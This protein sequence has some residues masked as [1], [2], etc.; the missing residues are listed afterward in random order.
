MTRPSS[1]R[2]RFGF[3]LANAAIWFLMTVVLVLVP[4]LLEEWVGLEVAR[5]IG[6]AAAGGLWMVTIE[7]QWQA[8]FGVFTRFALQLLLWISAA[9]VAIW[10]SE[11]TRP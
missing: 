6:W 3:V 8:R 9:L 2:G 5:V 1:A 11:I 4:D 10:I 7:R